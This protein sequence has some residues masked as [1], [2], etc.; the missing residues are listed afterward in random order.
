MYKLLD[1]LWFLVVVFELFVLIITFHY[2]KREYAKV[3]TEY[4]ENIKKSIKQNHVTKD[5]INKGKVEMNITQCIDA[6]EINREL[7]RITLLF[8][9]GESITIQK[10][11]GNKI[12]IGR[13]PRNDIKINDISVSR[14]QCIIAVNE[15]GFVIKNYSDINATRVNGE[16]V[17]RAKKIANGDIVKVGNQEFKFLNV[18]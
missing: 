9:N 3:L 2:L 13:D 18:S 17:K 1:I 16:K 6:E 11:V 7:E 10:E 15:D 14:K 8:S 12:R 4:S 5:V